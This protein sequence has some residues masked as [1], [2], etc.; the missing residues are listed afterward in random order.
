MNPL[1]NSY[2]QNLGFHSC[3]K[4]RRNGKIKGESEKNQQAKKLPVTF[5]DPNKNTQ[6]G[7]N[8]VCLRGGGKEEGGNDPPTLPKGVATW[9]WMF[10]V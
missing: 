4:C 5:N 7:F 10:A 9:G 2:Q 3:C 6:W 1:H 8:M